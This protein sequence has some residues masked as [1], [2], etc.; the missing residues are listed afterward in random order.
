M[1]CE[2]VTSA[3]LLLAVLAVER[4]YV[5]M[6]RPYMSLKMLGS[7]ELLSAIRAWEW[8]VLFV[9]VIGKAAVVVQWFFD[10]VGVGSIMDCAHG[11]GVIGGGSSRCILFGH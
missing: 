11:L 1:L 2:I 8:L 10:G 6:H 5:G 4:T 3:E 9:F 7:F